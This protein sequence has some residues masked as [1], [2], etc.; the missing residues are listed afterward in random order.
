MPFLLRV[1]L[2]LVPEP[3]TL[4]ELFYADRGTRFLYYMN[5]YTKP[6]YTEGG[7]P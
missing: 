7:L 2:Y 4:N 5:L 3:Y 6:F 1:C